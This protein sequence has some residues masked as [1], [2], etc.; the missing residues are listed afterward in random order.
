MTLSP[1]T[2]SLATALLLVALV[3]C[4]RV[5]YTGSD[6]RVT[7]LTAQALLETGRP[8]LDPYLPPEVIE[9]EITAPWSVWKSRGSMYN[10]YPPGTAILA[11]PAVAAARAAGLD[12]VKTRDDARLQILLVAALVAAIFLVF[13]RTARLVL[14]DNAAFW[15]SL[16]FVL[17]TSVISTIG[18]ALWAHGP[19]V[20]LGALAMW[21]LIAAHT[22][23][24]NP[25]GLVLG[26][27]LGT[28]FW[29]RPTAA[30][31]AALVFG[32]LL[33]RTR[34]EALRFLVAGG[35]LAA[36]LVAVSIA[37]L[38]MPL[39]TYYLLSTWPP[40]ATPLVGLLGVLISPGRGLLVFSPFLVVGLAG[41]GSRRLRHQ[42]LFLLASAWAVLQAVMVARNHDWWG[43]WCYGPRLLSDSLPAWFLLVVLA[44]AQL[45]PH[46]KRSS[47]RRAVVVVALASAAAFSVGVHTVQGL[48]NPATWT[49]ND[50]PNVY[51]A[52][53]EKLFDVS[54]PQ[55][56]AT[57]GRNNAAAER[58]YRKPPPAED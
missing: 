48:F 50:R 36:A 47:R 18:T 30:V 44:L 58:F 23:G 7:L 8:K 25:N 27:L 22:E 35:C 16:I 20:L 56:F 24:R 49:W 51:D 28:A 12:M 32:L 34:R 42:P 5:R 26:L 53:N 57:S 9:K 38:G 52:P 19:V 6:P 1:R 11:L 15:V 21:H 17:G 4:A 46:L 39:P 40:N 55:F 54:N 13:E 2:R 33:L 43:G 37:E 3:L 29:C 41:W 31:P 45:E 14:P 10:F